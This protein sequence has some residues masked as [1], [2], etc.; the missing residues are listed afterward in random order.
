MSL[1]RAALLQLRLSRR[2]S[3]T[4]KNSQQNERVAPARVASA[5]NWVNRVLK[6]SRPNEP[7]PTTLWVANL[8]LDVPIEELLR[9][10]LFGP[11]FRI[12]SKQLG[13]DRFVSLTFFE[14]S[15][16]VAFYR[17]ITKNEVVV[18][19]ARLR[20]E[21]G[22]HTHGLQGATPGS[23]VGTRAIFIHHI[24]RLGSEEQVHRQMAQFGP[25]DRIF[26]R[27]NGDGFVD[28]L[29]VNHAVRAAQTL[30]MDG[31]R[32]GFAEDRCLSAHR[33]YTAAVQNG[34]RQVI[35]NNV[36]S[37]TSVAELC[38]HIR[39]GILQRITFHPD[40][41]VAFVDFLK[42]E[43]AL[44]FWRHAFY[45]GITLSGQRLT[46]W[47]KADKPQLAR[48]VPH[49]VASVANHGA[50]RCL[51]ITTPFLSPNAI[52]HDFKRWGPIERAEIDNESV[53]IAY[54]DIEDSIKAW[55]MMHTRPGY[56][57]A[58]IE[59][60]PDPCG[61]PLAGAQRTSQMLQARMANILKPPP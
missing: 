8:P 50:S 9:L 21:W 3:T 10:V 37:D 4:C 40:N 44:A 22:R 31:L 32:V 11:I 45:R 12:K 41:R 56:E 6:P 27:P 26:F 46:A 30:R 16:A 39:G 42:P 51:R 14:H 18:R 49:L 36:P 52:R 25:L 57:S 23:R 54:L 58:R 59:F 17:E 28:F 20:F 33:T 19:G 15:T 7:R 55:R 34:A 5:T 13:Q 35:L 38:D 48:P 61:E 43:A 29:A 53:V 2:I 1:T 60:A 47:M 24:H